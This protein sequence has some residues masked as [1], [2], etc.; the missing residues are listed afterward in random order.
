M[1]INYTDALLRTEW[2]ER[3]RSI[4]HVGTLGKSF[5]RSC[6]WRFSV[7][8]WRSIRAVSG[9]PLSSGELEEAL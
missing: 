6:L 8:L 1:F 5:I 4:R 3:S 7:K 2:K 9:A